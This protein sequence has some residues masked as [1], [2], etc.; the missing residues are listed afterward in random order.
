M[1]VVRLQLNGHDSVGRASTLASL[2]YEESSS[3][4]TPFFVCLSRLF[5]E[6]WGSPFWSRAGIVADVLADWTDLV[7]SLR[8]TYKPPWWS[9]GLMWC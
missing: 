4:L 7:S 3:C 9:P 2:K 1:L 8:V 6:P 5:L